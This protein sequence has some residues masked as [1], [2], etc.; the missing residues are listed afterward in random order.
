MKI[1]GYDPLK[2]ASGTVK[3]SSTSAAGSS[4]FADLLSLSDAQD[5]PPP[6]HVS[7]IVSTNALNNLLALQ[8]IS[9]EEV[10]RKKLVQQGNNTLDA[11]ERLRNQLLMGG[12]PMDVLRDL[13]RNLELQKQTVTDPALMAL[14]TDIELRAAVELAKL[15]M[16]LKQ[17][18]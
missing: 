1:S 10:R 13:K 9:E 12:I 14:I 11:L 5:A 3:R 7:D 17:G 6:T 2:P 4:S 18:S 8:E 15:E 16:A